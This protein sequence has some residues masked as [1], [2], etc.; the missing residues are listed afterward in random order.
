MNILQCQ[1]CEKTFANTAGL[2]SH[3]KCHKIGLRQHYVK[4]FKQK[5][6]GICKECGKETT[7]N[8]DKNKYRV[9]CSSSC[10]SKNN[11]SCAKRKQTCI[12]KYG[13]ECSMRGTSGAQ[14]T[15]DTM[16]ERYGDLGLSHPSITN[17]KI[18]TNIERYGVEYV[19]Q[20]E[21]VKERV[22]K[23]NIERYGVAYGLELP[24]I[25]EK[26]RNT[27][28]RRHNCYFPMQDPVFSKTIT[29]K[30]DY[31]EQRRKSIETT[32]DRYGVDYPI[33]NKE[34]FLRQQKGMFKIK[35]YTLPSGAI[36]LRRGYE[37][38]FLDYIFS[39]KLINE[40][41]ITQY[42][43]S[44][45]YINYKGNKGYYY[46]DFQIPKLN[47][48][49]EIKSRY[50]VKLDKNIEQKR[51]ACIQHGYGYI[52]I[53]DNNFEEFHQLVALT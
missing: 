7:W 23:T 4:Y 35:E 19:S 40:E 51:E 28:F 29:D 18:K 49:V 11:E 22:R 47:L 36:V 53:V 1:I 42:P 20:D 50:T 17:K 6:E 2:G 48:I 13:H 27:F 21:H 39:N 30:I 8:R 43:D 25:Q 5:N 10:A 38:Q 45:P 32:R 14:K 37:P 24:E 12:N 9:F 33:Q 41:D 26:R 15:R 16:F 44:I 52:R 3:L 31:K 34:I 46:P